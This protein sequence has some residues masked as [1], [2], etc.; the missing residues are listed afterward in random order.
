MQDWVVLGVA[1]LV[2]LFGWY[3]VKTVKKQLSGLGVNTRIAI[4][5]SL[6][7]IIALSFSNRE[8]QSFVY[9]AFLPFIGFAMYLD[10][11]IKIAQAVNS[12]S[13]SGPE[14]IS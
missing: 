9:V 14:K 11:K 13:I 4:I 1:L 5:I 3:L 12:E 2:L 8:V 10:S 7:L 6:F